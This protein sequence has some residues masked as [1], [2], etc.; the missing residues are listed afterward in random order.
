ML[1]LS[2]VDMR[3][4]VVWAKIQG[5]SMSLSILLSFVMFFSEETHLMSCQPCFLGTRWVEDNQ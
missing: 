3:Q 5:I 4:V 1:L 2:H